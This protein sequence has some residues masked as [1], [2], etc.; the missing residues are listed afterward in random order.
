MSDLPLI[1]IGVSRVVDEDGTIRTKVHTPEQY[2]AVEALGLLV[3][4]AL[5]VAKDTGILGD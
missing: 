4:G 5:F 3:L 2:S 1:Q